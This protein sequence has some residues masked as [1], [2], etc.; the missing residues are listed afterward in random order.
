M[1]SEEFRVWA[2]SPIGVG[3]MAKL[4]QMN[5]LDATLSGDRPG[6]GRF[7]AIRRSKDADAFAKMS[8]LH[9]TKDLSIG[10]FIHTTPRP[11]G[12]FRVAFEG[13][14]KS[15]WLRDPHHGQ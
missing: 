1:E 3:V 14:G 11:K 13:K 8:Q 7:T 5:G 9:R 4:V 15:P 12:L 10:G 2:H 6:E